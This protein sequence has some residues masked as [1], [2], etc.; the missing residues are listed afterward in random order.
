MRIIYFHGWNEHFD[1]TKNKILSKFGDEVHFPDIYYSTYKNLIGSYTNEIFGK[2]NSTLI[3]GDSLGGYMAYHISN[4][5][6]CPALLFNPTFFFKN[7]GELHPNGNSEGN[8]CLD[9]NIILSLN[10]EEID[11]K[12]TLKLLKESGFD[13][14]IKI[15]DSLTHQIP[16][17]IFENEFSIFRETY[18]YHKGED[19]KKSKKLSSTISVSE[20]DQRWWEVPI[21]PMPREETINL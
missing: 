4:I 3:V 14:Q 1:E 6:K 10:D 20:E 19:Q 15:F 5:C 2:K 16:I 8:T 13:S 9:K 12:R 7:G 21:V 11:I 18:K 17:D